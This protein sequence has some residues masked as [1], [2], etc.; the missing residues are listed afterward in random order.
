MQNKETFA[1]MQKRTQIMIKYGL[2]KDIYDEM[3]KNGC[4]VCGSFENLSVDH[5][6]SCCEYKRDGKTCGKC[7]RGILCAS[8]NFAEGRMKSNPDL[9]LK[10]YKYVKKNQEKK[11]N[12][13]E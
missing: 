7:I 3:S 1:K 9:I 8:C 2:S 5:D 10:L 6:H 11:E 4:M 12:Y 13:F